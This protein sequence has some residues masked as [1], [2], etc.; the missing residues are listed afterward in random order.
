MFLFSFFEFHEVCG[1]A[2]QVDSQSPGA[3]IFEELF[4]KGR[5][6]AVKADNRIGEG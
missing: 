5:G 2:I 6:V 1:A 4:Q 3:T